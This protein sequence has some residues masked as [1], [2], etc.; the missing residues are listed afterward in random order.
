MDYYTRCVKY[1]VWIVRKLLFLYL[2]YYYLLFCKVKDLWEDKW[3]LE[4]VFVHNT[5]N[6]YILNFVIK[7]D[8][9]IN[10]TTV[11]IMISN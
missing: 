5:F 1:V 3:Y 8:E 7:I 10:I 6:N 2:L 11:R 9:D 4:K